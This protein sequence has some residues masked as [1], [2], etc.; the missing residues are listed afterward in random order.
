MA[1]FGM[2]DVLYRPKWDADVNLNETRL[3][4]V[5]Q[6]S[7]N[8]DTSE[9]ETLGSVSNSFIDKNIYSDS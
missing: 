4:L 5:Q 1:G 3:T 9:I 8:G 7:V 2:E 6:P